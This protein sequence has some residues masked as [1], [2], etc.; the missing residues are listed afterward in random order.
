MLVMQAFCSIFNM[1][2]CI[3][4]VV[5]RCFLDMQDAVIDACSYFFNRQWT[6]HSHALPQNG[7][8]Q[9]QTTQST[10]HRVEL[11]TENI[12]SLWQ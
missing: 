4:M 8:Y 3:I 1:G 10:V 6:Q 2:G 7:K 9:E 11:N 5:M 12:T